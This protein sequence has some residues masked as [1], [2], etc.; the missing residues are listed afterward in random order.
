MILNWVLVVVVV[1]VL[2]LVLDVGSE[3]AQFHG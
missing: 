3:D 2:V 1:F